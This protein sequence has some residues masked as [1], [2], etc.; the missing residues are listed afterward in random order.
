MEAEVAAAGRRVARG[1]P[2]G[3]EDFG[4]RTA[5]QRGL[6]STMHAP[7]R[8]KVA[9]NPWSLR[10]APPPSRPLPTQLRMGEATMNMLQFRLKDLLL[11]HA[12]FAVCLSL[13]VCLELNAAGIAVVLVGF[14]LSIVGLLFGRLGSGIMAALAVYALCA[15]PCIVQVEV[16]DGRRQHRCSCYGY[17]LSSKQPTSGASITLHD[18]SA[19][20][21]LGVTESDPGDLD[22]GRSGRRSHSPGTAPDCPH[23]AVYELGENALQ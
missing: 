23:N 6:E 20:S 1:Q 17:R 13:S 10:M 16:G 22:L 18:L 9:A 2:Y 8:P 19:E 3:G 4:S 7:H 5:E 21:K 12:W 14:G 15:V 11:L